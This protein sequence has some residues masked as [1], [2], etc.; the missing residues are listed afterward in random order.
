MKVA[1]D[2][3]DLGQAALVAV[4]EVSTAPGHSGVQ[5]R[6]EAERRLAEVVDKAISFGEGP[7]AR[8]LEKLDGPVVRILITIA[9]ES[10]YG[11]FKAA[12]AGAF[13]AAE[14]GAFKAAKGGK[15]AEAAG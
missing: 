5:K 6:R 13:K 9:I 10:A 1:F 7:M 8:L 12:E 2:W 15:A 4:A 14:A 3:Q 11:A